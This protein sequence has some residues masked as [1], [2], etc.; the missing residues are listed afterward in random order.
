MLASRHKS[1]ETEVADHQVPGLGSFEERR[2][3]ME[4]RIYLDE[5]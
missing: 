4:T 3:A 1:I 5:R 2:S